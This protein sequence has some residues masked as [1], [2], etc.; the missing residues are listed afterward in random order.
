MSNLEQQR[1]RGEK[2]ARLLADPIFIDAFAQV[3]EGIHAQWENTPIRD[4][5]GAH[6]LKLM[7]Q[8]LRRFQAVFEQTV[9]DGK[10]AA[11]ELEHLNRKQ[12]TLAEVRALRR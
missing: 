12:M 8:L 3:H 1:E 7:L 11:A 10:L 2:A 5:E 9:A 6:E 4:Q